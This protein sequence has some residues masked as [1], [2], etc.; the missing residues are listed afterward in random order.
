MSRKGTKRERRLARANWAAYGIIRDFVK[1]RVMAQ[2]GITMELD[3]SIKYDKYLP[4]GTSIHRPSLN[5]DNG[6]MIFWGDELLHL[7]RFYAPDGTIEDLLRT[8]DG[9]AREC[10]PSDIE[11]FSVKEKWAYPKYEGDGLA[12]TIGA[13]YKRTNN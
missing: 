2:L 13:R 4:E 9:I 12:H 3:P 7:R 10:L 8:L 6:V 5:S 1:E 11:L